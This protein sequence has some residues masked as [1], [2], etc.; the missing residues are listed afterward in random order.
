MDEGGVFV[1]GSLTGLTD[2][3]VLPA[4]A[5]V[6]L[7]VA[8]GRVGS[9]TTVV[10][11]FPPFGG[12]LPPPSFLSPSSLRFW[13]ASPKSDDFVTQK[14]SMVPH[15]LWHALIAGPPKLSLVH[16]L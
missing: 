16:C 10:P 4:G 11:L 5:V 14:N 7:P 2:G 6:Q 13:A 9:M 3:P 1:A 8:G 15:L 12:S